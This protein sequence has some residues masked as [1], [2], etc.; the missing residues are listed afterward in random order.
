LAV[1]QLGLVELDSA[2]VMLLNPCLATSAGDSRIA[3]RRRLALRVDP[4]DAA[5]GSIG[6]PALARLGI[7]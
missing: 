4:L 2:T 5:S 3:V 7:G 1:E 6:S